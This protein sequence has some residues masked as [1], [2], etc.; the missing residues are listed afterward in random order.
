MLALNLGMIN[1]NGKT[2]RPLTNTDNGEVDTETRFHYRQAGN[3][4]TCE[5]SGNSIV[6]GHLI[7]LVAEDG[8][9]TMRYHQVNK[10]GQLM[11]GICESTP[12]LLSDGRIRLHERWQWT[13]GDLSKGESVL[14][15]V[16]PPD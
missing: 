2:F 9:I 4:L 12:E 15:E 14:E 11:T 3:I 7:G 8:T 10:A 6:K 5:Y 16:S 13:S 1:Y